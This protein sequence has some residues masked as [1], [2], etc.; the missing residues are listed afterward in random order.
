MKAALYIRVSTVYQIE[1][2]SLP[3]QRQDLINYTKIILGIEDYE[4]FEDAGYS[5]KNTDL[6]AFQNMMNKIRKGEFTHILVWKLDRISRNLNDFTNMWEE[7]NKY[8]VQFISKNEQFDTSTAM[9]SAMLKII[10]VFAELE[11][12]MTG[13]RVK[14]TM[15]SR[16]E[17]GKWNGANVPLGY[18]FDD[19]TKY[20]IPDEKEAKIV[21]EMFDMYDKYASTTK[22]CK[23]LNARGVPTKRKGHWS[24]KTVADIF[25]NPFYKGTLRYNYRKT[26]HGKINDEADWVVVENNHEGII[27]KEQW[28]RVNAGMDANNTSK[29]IAGRKIA[30]RHVHALGGLIRC[31]YCGGGT[32]G[33]LDRP[34]QALGGWRPSYYRCNNATH[35]TGCTHSNYVTEIQI[36]DMLIN[37][38]SNVIYVQDHNKDY[39]DL[40]SLEKGLL[41]NINEN[42]YIDQ[43][44]LNEL[45]SSLHSQYDIANIDIGVQ[46]G[47]DNTPLQEVKKLQASKE[48][49]D[50]AMERWDDA[51]L[52]GDGDISEKEYLEKKNRIAQMIN[53]TQNQINQLVEKFRDTQAVLF[54]NKQLDACILNYN[55]GNG[56]A[57]DY[58]LFAS[59]IEDKSL[60]EFF[61]LILDHIVVKD[62]KIVEIVFK[63]GLS[64]KFFYKN[65]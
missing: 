33:C 5:A 64:Q 17:E 63:N 40:V 21:Q 1:K 14:A 29:N 22:I 2:D 61:C 48:K 12:K 19:E 46:E 56:N 11:S 10:L 6:P 18:K 38:I 47:D 52:F 28:E 57:I 15:I 8:G 51:Y 59:S 32:S 9:G 44:G 53:D 31:A 27:S 60:K 41:Q 54:D 16:A 13:E 45:F 30:T 23:E 34:R 4:I 35:G 42:V 65:L 26:P 50:K 20:P 25:R 62:K 55:L 49:Y 37:Y 7:F 39:N 36:G 58:K 3:M 24:S 43:E